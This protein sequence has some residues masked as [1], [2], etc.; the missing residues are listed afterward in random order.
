MGVFLGLGRN[1]AYGLCNLTRQYTTPSTP[2]TPSQTTAPDAK[3]SFESK[4]N[5]PLTKTKKILCVWAKKYPS[6]KETPDK[7][8]AEKWNKV[9]SVV[10]IK[11][12]NLTM[13]F[14]ILGCIGMVY[15]GKQA[16]DRGES[17]NQRNLDWHKKYS[18]SNDEEVKNI[19]VF[20]K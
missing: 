14:V 20:G 2:A 11:V 4:A 15:T 9:R 8:T 3:P 1:V 13:L 7:I 6:V 18:E 12:A 17:L 16:R 10:R 5:Y 19:G